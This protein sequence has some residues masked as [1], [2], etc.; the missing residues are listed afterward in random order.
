MVEPVIYE[1]FSEAK[2]IIASTTSSGR[3]NLL[4]GILSLICLI[5][6]SSSKILLRVFL[7]QE[8]KDFSKTI[9]GT[10][11][12]LMILSQVIKNLKKKNF[13]R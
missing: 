11:V 4:N 6:S 7:E 12:E 10:L 13:R 8:I 1:E 5:F 3:P 2:N 9:L